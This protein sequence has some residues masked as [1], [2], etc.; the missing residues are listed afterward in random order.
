MLANARSVIVDEIHAVAPNKRRRTSLS[1]ERLAALCGDRLQRIGL[2]A[3]RIRSIRRPFSLSAPR[4]MAPGY[5]GCDR[6]RGAS[7]QA[8]QVW[9]SRI[10]AR[11]GDVERS[12][13]GVYARLTELIEEHRTTLV[14]VNT[15][16]WPTIARELTDRLGKD[17]VTAH[18]GSM[19]KGSGSPPNSG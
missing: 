15:G 1:L 17:A 18:H 13:D 10:A 11:G 8:R 4:R 14:F 3:R 19:A 12:V 6:R 9:S 2:S 7:A 16:A 5:G